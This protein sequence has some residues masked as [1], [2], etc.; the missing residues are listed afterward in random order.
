[1]RSEKQIKSAYKKLSLKFHPDKIRPDPA[2][3]ETLEMLN[4]KYVEL[5]KAYQAL[6]DEEVRNNYIQYGNPDGKQGYSIG[7][8]L[9]KFIVSDGNGKYI[10]LIYALLMGVLLPYLVGSWWYGNLRL[11]KEG[12]LIESANRLFRE[13]E[14]SDDEGRLVAALS[15]GKEFEEQL[16]GD[17][18]E[19]GLAKIESRVLAS[20]ILS[21]RDLEKLESLE[22]VR[23]KVLALIWAYL[24]RVELEDPSL[25]NAKYM[26]APLAAG[27][28]QAY[29]GKKPRRSCPPS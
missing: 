18:A 14:D 11:S 9:P 1:M 26:V 29:N 25:E 2:K 22:G 15:T 12:V 3:N 8:A 17:K 27:L 7:I 13:Y 24:G 16:K 28:T 21:A 19:S 4:D 23:R 6:T 5:T 20:G 10:V